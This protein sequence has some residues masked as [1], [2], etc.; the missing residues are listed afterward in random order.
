MNTLS[1]TIL[2]LSIVILGANAPG[3]SFAQAQSEDDLIVN[4]EQSPLFDE[5]N[6]LPGESVERTVEVKNNTN[7]TKR[8]AVQA[9]NVSDPDNFGYAL[10]IEI[11]EGSDNCH[12]S[13]LSSFFDAGEVY[14]SD[15][16]ANSS[17][18][19]TFS[20]E[21]YPG[22]N[23]N[24]QGK[25]LGFD[26]LV[27]FQGEEG[28]LAPGA[29]T[30][31]GGGGGLPSGLT[32]QYEN[33]RT[34]TTT[35]TITWLTSYQSTS[36]VIYGTEPNQFDLYVGEPGYGYE[37]WT[38]E[39]DAPASE[40]GVTGHSVTITGLTEG[41]TY[42]F[43]CVSH[44][45]PATISK[46]GSFTT[47]GVFTETGGEQS[48]GLEPGAGEEDEDEDEGGIGEA[49]SID[50]QA[51][52]RLPEVDT[53]SESSSA[54]AGETDLGR[55]EPEPPASGSEPDSNAGE[56]EFEYGDNIWEHQGDEAELSIV[57]SKSEDD[58]IDDD[59]RFLAGIGTLFKDLEGW[60]MALMFL[61]GIVLALIIIRF[62]KVW[63][64][65]KR[66]NQ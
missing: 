33:S 48:Q 15:L 7:E 3:F 55:V 54:G 46:E 2:I 36:R 57:P 20:I 42:Y 4:F 21:F 61:L 44:A 32:I 5:A 39:Y 23:N 29:G 65:K 45:S 52:R 31:G 10:N 66:N 12:Q 14:L 41:E 47:L 49:E 6:F 19:Y 11:T 18:T 59:S 34:S 64:D 22:A 27:G 35:A 50:G 17:T 53:P 16:G 28:G 1:K 38:D 26:I 62:I 30:S 51:G 56:D 40:N 58:S 60:R 37:F 63:I 43:R 13:S 8:I 24:F 25:N 9:I